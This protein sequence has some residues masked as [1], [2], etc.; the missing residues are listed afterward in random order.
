VL[1]VYIIPAY[2]NNIIPRAIATDISKIDEVLG[3]T[4]FDFVIFVTLRAEN[5]V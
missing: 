1:S 2:I 3:P 5:P 4:T